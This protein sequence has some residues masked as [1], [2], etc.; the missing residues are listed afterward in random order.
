MPCSTDTILRLRIEFA[1][2]HRTFELPMVTW[3]TQS[4]FNNRNVPFSTSQSAVTTRGHD[5]TGESESP[6]VG[7]P[8]V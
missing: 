8:T 1:S 6:W 2:V 3:N 7:A 4:M 5:M